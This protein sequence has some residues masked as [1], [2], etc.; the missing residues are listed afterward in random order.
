MIRFQIIER[1]GAGLHK[2]LV[3]AMRDGGLRMSVIMPN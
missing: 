1:A 3:R 2:A